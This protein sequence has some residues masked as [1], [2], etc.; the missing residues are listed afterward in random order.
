MFS[1]DREKRNLAA[2]TIQ[3]Y[4]R[5]N[6]AVKKQQRFQKQTEDAVVCIQSVLRGHLTRKKFALSKAPEY[7]TPQEREVTDSDAIEMIQSAMKGHLTRQA[8]L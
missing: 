5:K 6:Q 7:T 3:C 1:S 8:A 2:S 4:W